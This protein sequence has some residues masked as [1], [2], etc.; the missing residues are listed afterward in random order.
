MIWLI[1]QSLIITI[2]LERRFEDAGLNSEKLT[3]KKR[4]P[5]KAGGYDVPPVS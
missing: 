1:P 4:G 5:Y 3:A 2:V